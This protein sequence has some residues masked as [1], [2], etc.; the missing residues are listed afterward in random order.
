ML[1]SPPVASGAAAP[2]AAMPASALAEALSPHGVVLDASYRCP[3]AGQCGCP[4]EL[5]GPGLLLQAAAELA[6]EL[7][8]SWLIGPPRRLPHGAAG[9]GWGHAAAAP[10]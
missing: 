10:A 2:R 1:I 7:R 8:R 6:L 4:C 5:P 3:H 9:S